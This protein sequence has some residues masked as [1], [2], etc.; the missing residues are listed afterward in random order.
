[1]A[2]NSK[3]KSNS[4]H[5]NQPLVAVT[6]VSG[7]IASV[8]VKHLIEEGYAVRGTVRSLTD[9]AKIQHL[10]KLFPT[11]ELFEADLLKPGWIFGML[12]AL[13]KAEKYLEFGMRIVLS[14][15]VNQ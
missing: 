6:G 2:S 14:F 13:T 10:K 12:R 8:L 9:Q 11:L 5:P 1:M 4:S 7:Y 15:N 3:N